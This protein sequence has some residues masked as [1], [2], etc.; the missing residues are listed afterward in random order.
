M[1]FENQRK[2]LKLRLHFE[3][4]KLIKNTQSGPLWQVF[5]NLKFVVR[6]LIGQKLVKNAKIQKFKWDILGN[7]KQCDRRWK[8]RQIKI[9]FT[10]G[11]KIQIIDGFFAVQ[12]WTGKG[13]SLSVLLTLI[14]SSGGPYYSALSRSTHVAP[15][16]LEWLIHSKKVLTSKSSRFPNCQLPHRC[17][18]SSD[19]V[20][21]WFCHDVV[22]F[23]VYHT[24]VFLRCS[25]SSP[26]YQKI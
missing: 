11:V 14:G 19:D 1:V 9:L 4:T 25:N 3:W 20:Q 6:Q 21:F 10:F 24:S 2:S 5:E 26:I 13:L 7:L 23:F 8:C 15:I 12:L 17:L 18:N 16:V 22:V